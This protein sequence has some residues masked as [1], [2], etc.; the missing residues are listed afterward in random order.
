M[1]SWQT[2]TPQQPRS[3]SSSSRHCHDR[4]WHHGHAA[5]A[6]SL[7]AHVRTAVRIDVGS[8]AVDSVTVTGAYSGTYVI[9]TSCVDRHAR[10]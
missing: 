5:T 9:S 10:S 2:L 8:A 7:A 3:H 4:H 1:D 6:R